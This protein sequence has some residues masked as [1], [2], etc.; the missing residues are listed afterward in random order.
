MIMEYKEKRHNEDKPRGKILFPSSRRRIA[1]VWA[2][3]RSV[4]QH[5]NIYI[6][7]EM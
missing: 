7:I 1:G 2:G 5:L 3:S 4:V 6:I